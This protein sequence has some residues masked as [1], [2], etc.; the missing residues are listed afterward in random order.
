MKLAQTVNRER[1]PL[2]QFVHDNGYSITPEF[3]MKEAS[4]PAAGA[5]L[6]KGSSR[7]SVGEIAGRPQSLRS[8]AGSKALFVQSFEDV[9]AAEW[10]Q[11]VNE[12][13]EGWLYQ[14]S[15]WIE[16]AKQTGSPSASF[17]LR[18]QQGNLA[19]VFPLYRQD[20]GRLGWRRLRRLYTGLS[21]PVIAKGL[22][23]TVRQTVWKQLFLEVDRIAAEQQ[24]DILQVRLTNIAPAY[25][26]GQRD[27][28][29]PL[30]SVGLLGPL[31]VDAFSISQ[32]LSRVLDLD[33]SPEQLLKEMDGDCRAAIRQAQRNGIT[34][35]LA[36]KRGDLLDFAE[37]H[38]ANWNRNGLNA[39]ELEYFFSMW[40][41]FHS[42]GAMKMFFARYQD[43]RIAAVIIHAFKDAAFY[44]A[45]CS[46]ANFLKLRPNNL[47]L[48]EATQHLRRCGARWF[49]VGYY[50][51]S[52]APSRKE[53]NIGQYKSQF[54][55]QRIVPWEGQKAYNQA[56]VLLYGLLRHG[57]HTLKQWLK[58][59]D[60]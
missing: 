11:L 10:D 29:N 26:P 8:C 52:H 27:D 41:R 50:Y 42:S 14:T 3:A 55:C 5:Q 16:Y 46:D 48:W 43:K 18:T 60:S 49:E 34:V 15:S 44:W 31:T 24:I 35:E 2:A 7:Q 40:D 17:A 19:A 1:N 47:L 51:P 4:Q 30:I 59:E 33:K 21:G 13:P 23:E 6:G 57:K 58:R 37:L 38:H 39:H 45:G 28:V 56:R 12:S 20:M 32:P 36:E 54:G 25:Q 53:F 22:Q 9:P